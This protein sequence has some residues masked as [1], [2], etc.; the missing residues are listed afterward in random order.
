MSARR[1]GARRRALCARFAR[2]ES[3]AAMVEFAIVALILFSFVFAIIDF[4][5]AL[6]LYNN[7]TNAAREGARFGATQF[8]P[9]GPCVTAQ[10]AIIERTTSR[11]REF[12]NGAAANPAQYVSVSCLP[13]MA[14]V[15]TRI[16]VS[17]NNYPFDALTPLP[18]LQALT[19]GTA[20]IPISSVV[21]FEGAADMSP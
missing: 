16:T 18:Q 12:N 5:R 21:R 10:A 19:L 1:A 15:P 6:F 4:G 14:G 8:G 20:T 2:S 11:I 7:L 9:G 17:I 3:G 13:L